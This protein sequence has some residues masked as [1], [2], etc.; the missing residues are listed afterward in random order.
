MDYTDLARLYAALESTT[1]RLEK[2]EM[3]AAAIKEMSSDEIRRFLYLLQ[4]RFYFK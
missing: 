3:V 1:K 4:G 2:T